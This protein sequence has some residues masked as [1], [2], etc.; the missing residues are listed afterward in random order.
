MLILFCSR[1]VVGVV[2]IWGTH[3][4]GVDGALEYGMIIDG[5]YPGCAPLASRTDR[6]CLLETRFATTGEEY[7]AGGPCT[8]ACCEPSMHDCAHSVCVAMF[9]LL[10]LVR[11]SLYIHACRPLSLPHPS[12]SLGVVAD[13]LLHVDGLLLH[14]E[15]Q[16]GEAGQRH[17]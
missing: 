4:C 9:V 2:R 1:F 6:V 16:G 14:V 17:P 10:G 3:A 7:P 13:S 12:S 15:H 11:S 5:S 8:A